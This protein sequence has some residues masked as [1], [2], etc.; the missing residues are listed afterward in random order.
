[1]LFFG[2]SSKEPYS[3]CT[4]WRAAIEKLYL[5]FITLWHLNLTK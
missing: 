2:Y 4:I 3:F 1:M 5:L